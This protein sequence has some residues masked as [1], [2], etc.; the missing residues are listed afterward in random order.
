MKCRPKRRW[1]LGGALPA[2][3]LM[4]GACGPQL[5]RYDFVAE[6]PSGER[7]SG[8]FVVDRQAAPGPFNPAGPPGSSA[9]YPVRS[10]VVGGE[11][12]R[13]SQADMSV[14]VTDE[15]GSGGL[16]VFSVV[17]RVDSLPSP[18]DFNLLLADGDGSAFAS[19]ELP[20]TFPTL[21]SFE[22]NE[23]TIRRV[24]TDASDVGTAFPV[25]QGALISIIARPVPLEI[26]IEG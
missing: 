5:V 24:P 16:D 14:R 7:V 4:L 21:S 17:L 19:N 8:S 20:V 2:L 10:A 3:F 18:A 9:G 6:S 26:F 22:R 23:V 12:A 11:P 13:G 15:A 1:L 25:F